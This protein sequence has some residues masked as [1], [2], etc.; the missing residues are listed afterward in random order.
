MFSKLMLCAGC[1]QIPT[2]K[3]VPPKDGRIIREIDENYLQHLEA[4]I[5][6]NPHAV[7][8]PLVAN[9]TLP[10]GSQL[11]EGNLE[12]YEFEMIG[13]NHSRLVFQRLLSDPLFQ[14]NPA[15]T[16]RSAVVYAN[17]NDDEALILGQEH[18]TAAEAHLASKFQDEVCLARNLLQ[19]CTPSIKYSKHAD[20]GEQFHLLLKRVFLI[21]VG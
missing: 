21:E 18:N 9:I 13:G 3:M 20:G 16:H 5:K 15:V 7:V 17:L 4:K 1:Y 11:E 19:K 10:P 2:M 12:Y 14:S 8:A 6:A